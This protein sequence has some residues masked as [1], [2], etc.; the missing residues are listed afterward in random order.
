MGDKHRDLPSWMI[1]GDAKL[2]EQGKPG[3]SAQKTEKKKKTRVQRETVYFMNEAEL[4]G[5][6]LRVLTEEGRGNP[7]TGT[8]AL[9]TEAEKNRR[10]CLVKAN[11]D[12][13]K[14]KRKLM[15]E[16]DTE[17]ESSDCELSE[18]A[19]I[20]KTDLEDLAEK[21]TLPYVA[22]EPGSPGLAGV[23]DRNQEPVLPS[24]GTAPGLDRGGTSPGSSDD[25]ALRLV[26]EIFFT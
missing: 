8:L 3:K 6:A 2:S 18:K 23:S 26:R 5:A 24:R 12:F 25:E 9:Q 19:D 17:E 4:V 20:S 7:G 1:G 16:S 14:R 13:I 22:Q 21:A 11:S 15:F 10:E